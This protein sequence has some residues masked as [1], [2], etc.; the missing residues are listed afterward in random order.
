M[1]PLAQFAARCART[2]L[3]ALVAGG[4]LLFAAPGLAQTAD[5]TRPIV[6]KQKKP[7]TTLV[8]FEGTVMHANPAQITVRGKANELAV[9]TFPLSTELGGKMQRIVDRGGYQYGDKVTILYD[10]ASGVAQKIKGKP[11]KPV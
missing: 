5:T 4:A 10:P 6:I 7:K 2:A 9:R 1:R 11:S 8:K 3:P